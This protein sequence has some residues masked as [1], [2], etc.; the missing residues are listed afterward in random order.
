MVD[1]RKLKT[2]DRLHMHTEE[3]D[4]VYDSDGVV[5]LVDAE[6]ALMTEADGTRN[7]IDDDTAFQ[8]F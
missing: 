4:G 1:Y 8:F 3:F 7:W 6:H 2:G 5:S